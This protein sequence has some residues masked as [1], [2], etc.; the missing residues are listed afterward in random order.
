MMITMLATLA[1]RM[2]RQSIGRRATVA[3][4]IGNLRAPINRAANPCRDL[5][6]ATRRRRPD[7][8]VISIS[9]ILVSIARGKPRV[10]IRIFNPISR[11]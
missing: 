7:I 10:S 5:S 4:P 11:R 1:V 9:S 8:A 6:S 3:N 2:A